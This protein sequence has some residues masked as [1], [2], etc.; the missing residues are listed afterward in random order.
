MTD[1]TALIERRQ[2]LLGRSYRLFY[3]QP[4]YPVRGEGVWLYEADGRRYLDAYNN[5][6]S[7]GHCHPRVVEAIC[8]QAS[9]LNTHT[10]YLHDGILE[11]AERLLAL[12]P[13][14][15]NNLTLTCSGSE[16]NDLAL[17][18]ARE[19][20][21]NRIALVT[22]WAYHG[23]TS[24]IAELSP[25]LGVGVGDQVRL[26]D[27]PDS[28]RAPGQWLRQLR[29]QLDQLA[30]EGLR[31]AALM[32]DGLFSSDGVFSPPAAEIQQ[33]VNWVRQAG[34][35]YIADEVQSGFARTG[36]AFW[37]FSRYQVEPDLVTLGKPMGNG[38]PVAGMVARADLLDQFGARQRYFNTFGG[39]PVSCAAALAVLDVIETEHLQVNA[40]IQGQRL[41]RRLSELASQHVVIGDIRGAGLFYGVELVQ[42]RESLAPATDL[43]SR[44][45]NGMR[46]AGV[47]ISATG[48]DANILKI[49]P[50][51]VFSSEHV[52]LLSDTLDQVL[53]GLGV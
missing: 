20:T 49:R 27:A 9:V 50:P 5:V 31:P 35:L 33:A 10:R 8:R 30:A 6:V 16:A 36:E 7:V 4:L 13:E 25:A 39:N 45:V 44:V 42:D 26:L 1:H 3:Q 22:R 23:T 32:M 15:L 38:H 53:T 28:Y 12:F 52:E 19:V 17:R 14:R 2:R 48:P 21:G 18:V 40:R 43:A 47:L 29:Q 24:S 34:G 11:Y 41:Q 51:L 46:D 37:G